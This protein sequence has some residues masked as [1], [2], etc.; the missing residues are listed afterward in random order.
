MRNKFMLT[1]GAV[2]LGSLAL[3][4][5]EESATDD[6]IERDLET[7][8]ENIEAGANEMGDEMREGTRDAI[9]GAQDGL[10]D[11]EDNMDNPD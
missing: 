4:G 8:G 1:A 7:A 10:N 5:C 9:D 6:A 3:V 2:A 11:L